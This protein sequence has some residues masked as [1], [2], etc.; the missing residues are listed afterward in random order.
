MPSPVR[1]QADPPSIDR[2]IAAVAAVAALLLAGCASLPGDARPRVIDGEVE[3]ALDDP[4]TCDP[5]F[6]S[7]C[8]DV[9]ADPD[10]PYIIE[11]LRIVTD[12][13]DPNDPPVV[14]LS[15][16]GMLDASEVASHMTTGLRVTDLSR[17]LIIRDVTVRGHHS[18]IKVAS[19]SADCP[20]CHATLEN[21][22]LTG[23]CREADD[24]LTHCEVVWAEGNGNRSRVWQGTGVTI[25]GPQLSATVAD[26]RLRGFLD[27]VTTHPIQG[28]PDRMELSNL[29]VTCPPNAPGDLGHAG[30]RLDADRIDVETVAVSGCTRNGMHLEGEEIHARNLT[31]AGRVPGDGAL[32]EPTRTLVVEDFEIADARFG[33]GVKTYLQ[34]E[35]VHARLRDGSVEG[36]ERT[37]VVLD[38]KGFF[39][40]TD[41]RVRNLTLQNNGDAGNTS[42]LRG[43]IIALGGG[44]AGTV[45]RES[46]IEGNL[47]YG[48]AAANGSS[49]DAA[50]NWWG[51][52]TG[53]RQ[54]VHGDAPPVGAGDG[55]VVNGNVDYVPF[56]TSP[57]NGTGSARAS[58]LFDDP[59]EDSSTGPT[60]PSLAGDVWWP[61]QLRTL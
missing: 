11:G 27:G 54:E 44:G 29:T 17:D 58:N 40:V 26:S 55:D 31:V 8:P 2:Q 24:T 36:S 53:P 10:T 43:G 3:L 51:D 21:L 4:N 14:E 28:R 61:E 49:L 1:R 39:D 48:A 56:W 16:D 12:P 18:A 33:L 9:R 13:P 38:L 42:N 50:W 59:V 37:G 15:E 41:V 52:E 47:P 7:N 22:D 45:V 5:E 35:T 6:V 34:N 25:L 19:G 32:F 20:D 23:P 46:R 30:L 57:D 60:V